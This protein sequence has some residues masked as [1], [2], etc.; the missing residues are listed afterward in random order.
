MVSS[1]KLSREIERN[2][3]V[4]IKRSFVSAIQ[5][6]EEILEKY[7]NK[8]ESLLRLHAFDCPEVSYY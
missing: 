2:I 4:D 1:R 8:L 3:I 7:Q 5:N 6:R